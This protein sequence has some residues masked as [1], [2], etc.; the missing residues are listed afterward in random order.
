MLGLVDCDV[1]K[2]WNWQAL[3]GNRL[4]VHV[5]LL[6]DVVVPNGIS[7]RGGCNECLDSAS[8]RKAQIGGLLLLVLAS[9]FTSLRLSRQE[10][11]HLVSPAFSLAEQVRRKKGNFR[12][13][14]H[15]DVCVHVLEEEG[16]LL[17]ALN[18]EVPRN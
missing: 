6:Q 13:S 16:A 10:K 15:G 3:G 4:S 7:I 11:R 17:G 14:R 2:S 18:R 1:M 8:I 9:A 5:R 12:R